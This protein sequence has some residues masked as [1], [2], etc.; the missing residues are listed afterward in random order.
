MKRA[1]IGLK[2]LPHY[3][4]NAFAAGARRLGYEPVFNVTAT[5]GDKDLLVIWNRFGGADNAADAFERA[6]CPVLVAENG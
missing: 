6:G 3:R 1:W 2:E 5:P 4:R